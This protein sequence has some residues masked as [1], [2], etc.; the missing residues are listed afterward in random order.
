MMLSP[1]TSPK[2]SKR[3][4]MSARA[5]PTSHAADST[6]ATPVFF[7]PRPINRR[8]STF[9]TRSRG[10]F[11]S[12]RT[13]SISQRDWNKIQHETDTAM[14]TE[15]TRILERKQTLAANVEA[16]LTALRKLEED[17]KRQSQELDLNAL[18]D[19]ELDD[20]EVELAKFKE[21]DFDEEAMEEKILEQHIVAHLEQDVQE[22]KR[23]IE[24]MNDNDSSMDLNDLD[25]LSDAL[26]LD[27]SQDLDGLEVMNDGEDGGSDDDDESPP[28]SSLSQLAS[29]TSND[30][31]NRSTVP[32]LISSASANFDDPSITEETHTE[33]QGS[34]TDLSISTGMSPRRHR[35]HSSGDAKTVD[36]LA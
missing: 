33:R 10:S 36:T 28:S 5:M 27:D 29:S 4:H 21:E 34:D 25:N 30:N 15:R 31:I 18:D 8:G 35:V 23:A 16:S 32:P 12:Y 17:A 2:A 24:A 14:A 3:G 1:P 9:S 6:P 7:S 26:D 22:T 20:A 19:M 13:N 11:S